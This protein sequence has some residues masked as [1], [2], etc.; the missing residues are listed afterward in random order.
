MAQNDGWNVVSTAPIPKT[1]TSDGWNVVSTSP[2]PTPQ[3]GFFSS[4]AD[5]SGLSGLTHAIAHPIDTVMGLPSAIS[6]AYHQT[7]DNLGQAVDAAKSGN[8]AGVLSHGISA[9]PVLGPTLDKATDQYANKNY[10]GEMGTLTGLSAGIVAPSAAAKAIPA[11]VVGAGRLGEGMQTLGAKLI[12]SKFAPT[13]KEV[14]RGNSPG[15]GILESGIGTTLSKG[16]LANKVSGATEAVGTRI[17]DAV[18]RADNNALATPILS[19]DL[20]P[21]IINPINSAVGKLEGP[22]GTSSTA[23]YDAMRS[24]LGNTAPGASSPIYGPNAP[25]EIAPSDLWKH[26]QNLDQN[27]RFNTDPEVESVNETR[28]DIRQGL[29]PA[30]EASDPTIKPLSRTYSDLLSAGGAIDRTQGGFGVP[31]GIGALVDSTVKSTPLITGGA[32]SLFKI[33][34]GLKSI[35]TNAP[36]WLGGK[37]GAPATVGFQPKGIS[38]TPLLESSSSPSSIPE[39]GGEDFTLGGVQNKPSIVTPYSGE[40]L[41]LPA[42][43]G[44]SEA[45]PM[46]GVKLG[47]HPGVATDF[48]RERITPTRFQSPQSV[49]GRGFT[50]SANGDVMP[51]RLL[52]NGPV[53][54]SAPT[55][56]IPNTRLMQLLS[57][58]R[59]VLKP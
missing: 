59:K 13:M 17:G 15:R 39:P 35:A 8:Y 10:A 38:N 9:I 51:N 11:A 40:R 1:A 55:P 56:S 47:N 25:A 14:I 5:S 33:G 31:K 16:N 58:A 43:S 26:I 34:G 18:T 57:A 23:P 45:Q 41:R 42:T 36:E 30:L 32:S 29:R 50:A 28:R 46:I 4:A 7:A 21:A 12:D 48:G 52:L 49:S 20:A 3:Q 22:F 6:G 2:L 37:G 19:K 27:T 24:K 54:P 44:G 53:A